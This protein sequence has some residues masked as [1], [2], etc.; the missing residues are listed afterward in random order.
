VELA[1]ATVVPAAFWTLMNTAVLE[2]LPEA[3]VAVPETVYV[4]DT[5]PGDTDAVTASPAELLPA[6]TASGDRIRNARSI[7]DAIAVVDF[8]LVAALE[9]EGRGA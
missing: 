3:A 6:N 7:P 8:I 4:V 1:T 9:A 2:T 5:E